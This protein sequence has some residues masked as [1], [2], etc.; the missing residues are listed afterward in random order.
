VTTKSTKDTPEQNTTEEQRPFGAFL[1]E[2]AKGR[3]HEELSRAL[4]ELTSAVQDTRKPG[5][6]TLRID[7]KPHKNDAAVTVSDKVTVKIPAFERLDS[8]FFVD[9][10]ANLVRNDPHQQSFDL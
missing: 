5:S 6:L 10:D 9:D 4:R 2:L 8:I 7:I 3:T 1:H